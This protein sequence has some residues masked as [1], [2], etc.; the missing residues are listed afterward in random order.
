MKQ[1]VDQYIWNCHICRRAKAPQDYYNG[2]LKLLPVPKRP[3]TNITIDFVT[4][5]PECELK[6]E[7]DQLLTQVA[8]TKLIMWQ[9]KCQKGTDQSTQYMVT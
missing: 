8:S 1:D 9:L 3:W 5:L 2:T 6:N 7:R 4:G